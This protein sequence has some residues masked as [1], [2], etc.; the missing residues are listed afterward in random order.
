MHI[1]KLSY[2][3]SIILCACS[4]GNSNSG[5]APTNSP[6]SLDLNGQDVTHIN[7]NDIGQVKLELFNNSINP[8]DVQ[9]IYLTNI[10]NN[11]D[12]KNSITDEIDH[13]NTTCINSTLNQNTKCTLS[14]DINGI[15]T[16]SQPININ[17]V[18]SQGTTSIP[19]SVWNYNVNTSHPKLNLTVDR[20]IGGN[21]S[22]RDI[23]DNRGGFRTFTL[24]NNDNTRVFIDSITLKTPS[25]HNFIIDKQNLCGGTLSPKDS[26]TFT[27][28]Y[29]DVGEI[30]PKLSEEIDVNYKGGAYARKYTNKTTPPEITPHFNCKALG[31]CNIS[32]DTPTKNKHKIT[33]DK[34][35]FWSDPLQDYINITP[36]A[37]N[38]CLDG[39][40]I[41]TQNTCSFD[42][43]ATKVPTSYATRIDFKYTY[44]IDG[45]SYASSDAISDDVMKMHIDNTLEVSYKD[46]EI[47]S[48]CME[49]GGN[50]DDAS[51]RGGITLSS[52]DNEYLIKNITFTPS[53]TNYQD[54]KT[55][56][57]ITQPEAV[58]NYG[59]YHDT[60]TGATVK[61]GHDCS[62]YIWA[63]CEA[64][65][66]SAGT[67]EFTYIDKKNPTVDQK[68]TETLSKISSPELEIDAGEGDNLKTIWNSR[69]P[70][71]Q[72]PIHVKVPPSITAG[73]NI[74][75]I[76]WRHQ[77]S[78]FKVG[79][80]YEQYKFPG[81]PNCLGGTGMGGNDTF[82]WA[83]GRGDLCGLGYDFSKVPIGTSIST[84]L[85]TGVN[86]EITLNV[87]WD[88]T[89]QSSL[90]SKRS[91]KIL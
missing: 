77:S 56:R 64:S 23:L 47:P 43:T 57:L 10:T 63:G 46:S 34:Y 33:I 32:F 41:S 35:N 39:L 85:I 69:M 28:S 44:Y 84:T 79:K 48:F 18:T 71:P 12:T 4:A 76:N 36:S 82:F 11:N 91:K 19:I 75:I 40:D 49:R 74:G 17:F 50:D 42:I 55:K 59:K 54:Y 9:D 61:K 45:A 83:T 58:A 86:Q 90:K 6:L 27:V 15:Y 38:G 89:Q 31:V 14:L 1:K 29:E 66:D 22:D 60:C 37:Q 87:I 13:K 20:D 78:Y 65:G 8:I 81:I 51:H 52:S 24:S 72:S 2:L 3:I 70:V 25:Q 30:Y 7:I 62:V 68:L 53:S 26:C 80:E 5:L 16:Q 67:L 73:F 21:F 88:I